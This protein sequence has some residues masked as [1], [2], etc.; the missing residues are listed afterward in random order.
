MGPIQPLRGLCQD[1]PLS[2]YLFILCAEVLSCLIQAR[3]VAGDI[4]GCSVRQVLLE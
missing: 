1:D 4:H 3:F 2:P